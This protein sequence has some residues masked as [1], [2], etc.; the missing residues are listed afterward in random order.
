MTGPIGPEDPYTVHTARSAHL[1]EVHASST[2]TTAVD[3]TAE[4]TDDELGRAHELAGLHR[5]YLLVTYRN[6]C[7]ARGVS[8]L[9]RVFSQWT[10]HE[11][12]KAIVL[13]ERTPSLPEC[14]T[15]MGLGRKCRRVQD[16]PGGHRPIADR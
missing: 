16:H 7:R 6:E 8:S 1:R 13:L 9:G 14:G 4:L 3:L 12:A 11:L 2:E 15:G 10:Q 5:S